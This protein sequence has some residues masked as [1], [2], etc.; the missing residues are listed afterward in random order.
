MNSIQQTQQ[1][2]P[3]PGRPIAQ[4]WMGLDLGQSQD[5]TAL[6]VVERVLGTAGKYVGGGAQPLIYLPDER[7]LL[8]RRETPFNVLHLERLPLGTS[9]ATIVQI[10]KER[11]EALRAQK[12]RTGAS[13]WDEVSVKLAVD[14]TGVG[15][16]VV[17]LLRP[18]D[19]SLWAVT[20]TGGDAVTRGEHRGEW[21]VP[22]RD[23]VGQLQALLQTRRLKVAERLP[24]AA[25]LVRELQNFKYKI[26]V[27]G[28]D[29]YEA[30]RESAHDDL[31][32][33]VAIACWCANQYGRAMGGLV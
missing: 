26:S 15:R 14:G 6:S 29:S 8:P 28:H 27:A 7:E 17:D 5:Y 24:E 11:M 25:T 4:L 9:Y 30:W 1:E 22:K 21:R 33:S 23:L 31:V 13:G 3:Q 10:V 2:H 18:L 19:S 32:L 20:I 16:A 12:S